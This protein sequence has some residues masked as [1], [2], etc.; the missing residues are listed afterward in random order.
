MK[1]VKQEKYD[2]YKMIECACGCGTLTKEKD[3]YGRPRRF[4][5]GHNGRKYDDP[6]QYKREWNKRNKEYRKQ[7]K[8]RRYRLLK[9]KVINLLGGECKICKEKYDGKNAC[10]F[11]FHHRDPSL[12]ESYIPHMLVNVAWVKVLKELEKC[13]LLCSNCHN[14]IHSAEF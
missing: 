8:M 6:K 4:V 12:R 2:S 5:S 3:R 9:A 11:E 7:V 1:P 10:I 14:Q 13:D